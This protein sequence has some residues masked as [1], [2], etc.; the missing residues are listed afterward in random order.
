[1]HVSWYFDFISPFAYL[2]LDKVLA[3]RERVPVTPVPILFAAVLDAIGQ[4][5]P[6]E[7]P[8]KRTF[9]YRH[10]VWTAR[11]AGTPLTFP[12]RHPFNPLVALRLSVA[13]G[14]HWDAIAAIYRHLWRDGKAGDTLESLAGL[15]ETLGVDDIATAT[16]EP[17]VKNALRTNTER[18]LADGVFGVPTIRIDDAMFWGNDATDM[19]LAY[20][21]DPAMFDAEE[22]R[23]VDAVPV[24]VE[25]KR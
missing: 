20:L 23:R 16:A 3:L 15:A 18:A 8:A 17:A 10:I 2:Q 19:A 9:V 12:P 6:A 13:C 21:D 4:I 11:R 5:G 25:R 14:N 24:G 22:Y 1:M 7:I